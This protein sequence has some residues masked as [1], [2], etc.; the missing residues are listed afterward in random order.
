MECAVHRELA[1]YS[2]GESKGGSRRPDPGGGCCACTRDFRASGAVERI[3]PQGSLTLTASKIM[4]KKEGRRR[5]LRFTARGA[6]PGLMLLLFT[7]A[8]SIVVSAPA[9]SGGR[10]GEGSAGEAGPAGR[11]ALGRESDLITG[12]RGRG[13]PSLM[14]ND[15]RRQAVDD[16]VYN[17][18]LIHTLG[19]GGW[20]WGGGDGGGAARFAVVGGEDPTCSVHHEEIRV[21]RADPNVSKTQNC[22]KLHDRR[23]WLGRKD[24]ATPTVNMAAF[25]EMCPPEFLR[26]DR[27]AKRELISENE[28]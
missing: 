9:G 2:D 21:A 5:G 7:F 11:R 3:H 14:S 6:G 8:L 16:L 26:L 18:F 24:D 4:A 15:E 25:P 13:Y 19:G 10:E 1:G 28:F 23:L 22:A 20:W 12:G 27:D 17:H